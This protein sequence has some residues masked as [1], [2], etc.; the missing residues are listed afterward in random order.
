MAEKKIT[1]SVN[2]ED[3]VFN[4]TSDNFNRF[5]NETAPDDKILPAKRFLR[6]SLVDKK[7]MEQLEGI[8]DHGHS[9]TLAAKLV[10]DFQGEV[11]IEV[12]K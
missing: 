5:V 10:E 8:C 11:E 2:K 7:Q 12:K 3:I 6:R 4:V 9:L 1:I